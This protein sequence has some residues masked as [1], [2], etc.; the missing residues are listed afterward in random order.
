MP[1]PCPGNVN[2]L[3]HIMNALS[4]TGVH[5]CNIA[6]FQSSSYAVGNASFHSKELYSILQISISPLLSLLDD[7]VAKTRAHAASEYCTYT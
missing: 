1:L 2:N 5:P 4:N 3:L 7:P 6:V